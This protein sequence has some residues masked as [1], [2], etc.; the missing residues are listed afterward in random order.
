MRHRLRAVV[1]RRRGAVRVDVVDVLRR[2]GRR[3][4]AP[5]RIA[6]GRAGAVRVGRGQVVGVGGRAV[7]EHLAEDRR[8]AR[9]RAFSASS[10]T[11]TPAPSPMTKPSR[12]ASNGREMPV[13]DSASSAAK[14]A[15]ASGVERRLRA[16][17][18]RRRRRRR[19]RSS[20]A[21]APIACAPAAQAD[22][23]P[24]T[25]PRSP[26]RMASG[27]RRRRCSSSAGSTSGEHLARRPARAAP[28]CRA[29]AC[30]CRRCR[31]R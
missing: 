18:R 4:R 6:V 22:T 7:A 8:A 28:R 25:W 2:R 5:L 19:R 24:K 31:C 11:S 16:A 14:A 29:R 30:R 9:A 27:G 21:A 17:G 10:S 1:E 3:R 15:R 13:V 12:R 20:R 23:T 26:W